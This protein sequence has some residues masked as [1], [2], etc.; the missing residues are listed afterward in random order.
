MRGIRVAGGKTEIQFR[1]PLQ[2]NGVAVNDDHL[3]RFAIDQTADRL[4]RTA[5]S[6]RQAGNVF[7]DVTIFVVMVRN[8]DLVQDT[9]WCLNNIVCVENVIGFL[10]AMR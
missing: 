7:H 3:Q 4:R 5:G 10:R 2:L 8:R 6:C 9:I 1:T